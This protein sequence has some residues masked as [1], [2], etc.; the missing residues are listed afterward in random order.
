MSQAIGW[1]KRLTIEWID[2]HI[3][4]D[5]QKLESVKIP[6]KRV[7]LIMIYINRVSK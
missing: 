6:L 1:H 4:F 3:V 5:V 2:P 7:T